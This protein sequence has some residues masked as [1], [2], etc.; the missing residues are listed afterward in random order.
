MTEIALIVAVAVAASLYA[1][2][3]HGGASAYL[4][5]L[6]LAGRARPEIA[7]S[8]LVMNLLV[9]SLSWMRFWR[10]G[11]S[12]IPLALTLILFSA[13]AAFIGGWMIPS[14]RLFSIILGLALLAAAARFFLPDPNPRV[15]KRPQ[16]KALWAPAALMGTSL[17]LLAGL[18]GIGGGIYLSPLLL[19]LGWTGIKATAGVSAAFIA[20]NSTAGLTARFLRGEVF[21]LSFLPLV[22]AAIAGGFLG[23][24]WGA[25]HAAPITLR[26]VLGI[27]LVAAGFKL[28]L[29]G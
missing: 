4:A 29:G 8:V 28:L 22:L 27:V 20:I 5:L 12:D 6:T 21:D 26:R 13:P 10:A 14:P 16:A 9:S 2:V 15:P 17:G 7:A 23:A 25:D 3:G 18:T 1:S 24:L 11:Y 19:L